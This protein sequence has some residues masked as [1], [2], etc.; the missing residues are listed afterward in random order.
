MINGEKVDA[1]VIILRTTGCWWAHKKGCTM[2]GYN[3]VSAPVTEEDL[4]VQ[5]AKALEKYG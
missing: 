4:R 3:T 5:L 2:C 1:F